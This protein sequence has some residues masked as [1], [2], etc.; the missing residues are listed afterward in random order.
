MNEVCEFLSN[1]V[2]SCSYFSASTSGTCGDGVFAPNEQCHE[3]QIASTAGIV[4]LSTVLPSG[5]FIQQFD[6]ELM[7]V[8]S[9]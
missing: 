4:C 3:L 7:W 2:T 5:L 6:D 9:W 1:S 8:T